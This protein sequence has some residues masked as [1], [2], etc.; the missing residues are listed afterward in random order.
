VYVL[1][2]E[3]ANFRGIKTADWTL[4]GTCLCLIG[5]NDSTKTTLLDAIEM[6]LSPSPYLNLSEVDFHLAKTDDPVEIRVT[7][8]G[9]PSGSQLW[10]DGKFGFLKRGWKK[11][12]GLIDEPEDE[13]CEPVLTIRLRVSRSYEPEWAVMAERNL[14]GV[15]IST[16]NRAQIGVVRLGDDVDRDLAWG[17][18]SVLTRLTGGDAADAVIAE[19]Q[20]KL[21]SAA[22]QGNIDE[23]NKA[24][25]TV[26]EA[27]SKLGV[28]PT[29]GYQAALDSKLVTFRQGAFALHDGDI[30]VRAAGLGTRRLTA[31]AIQRA[32]V[33]D[34]AVVLIDEVEHGLEPHRIRRLL[35]NLRQGLDVRITEAGA[36][37][38]GQVIMTTHSAVPLFELGREHIRVVRPSSGRTEVLSPSENTQGVLRRMPSSFLAR[39]VLVCEGATEVGMCR[40]LAEHWMHAHDDVPVEHFGVEIADGGGSNAPD[41]AIALAD[42]KYVV[43]YIGDSDK[44]KP[45]D[46]AKMKAKGVKVM[47]WD[48]KLCTEERIALDLPDKGLAEL[49]K[50]ACAARGCDS[51]GAVISNVLHVAKP[52]DPSKVESWTAL[53]V[54][55]ADFRGA[56]GEGAKG[57]EDRK[58]WFKSID[59]GYALGRIIVGHLDELKDSPLSARL[60]EVEVWC[61]DS[62]TW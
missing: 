37:K 57:T 38:L 17:R 19:A 46:V 43:A 15:P 56:F 14:E 23:L 52:A 42:L 55:D 33:P 32:S 47:V 35:R 9:I 60:K 24:A 8:G 53:G 49:L 40:R 4:D 58:G 44:A 1:R 51:I 21:R 36:P 2:V 31:L 50:L 5:S 22:K 41:A 39:R 10:T 27:A 45:S 26:E 25:R 62:A 34:G 20:R 3:I 30:P 6:A 54:S 16:Q 11:A 48:G 7:V 59:G 13:E 61:Y 12:S 28:R 29:T 18:Y